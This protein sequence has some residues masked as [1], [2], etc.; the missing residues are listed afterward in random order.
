VHFFDSGDFPSA[1]RRFEDVIQLNGKKRAD[2]EKYLAQADAA[3]RD[4]RVFSGGVS[5]F[6]AGRFEDARKAFDQLING[7]GKRGAEARDY[8]KRIDTAGKREASVR[9]AVSKAQAT[10]ADPKQVAQQFVTDAQAAFGRKEYGVAL[11]KLGVSA[12]LDPARR[13]IR[14]LT[15]DVLEQALRAGL[16]S[17]FKAQYEDAIRYFTDYLNNNGRRSSLA[18][19]FRGAAHGARYYVSGEQDSAE[20]AQAAA[21]FRALRK[22]DQQVRPLEE[23]APPKILALYSQAS[24]RVGPTGP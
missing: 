14:R 7:G 23:F 6:E 12:A 2:A 11:E 20:K 15:D 16:E 18:Y 21:D 19:F 13:D 8:L 17:Y 10:S 4:D 3:T 5:A 24:G 9:E 1:R 22:N